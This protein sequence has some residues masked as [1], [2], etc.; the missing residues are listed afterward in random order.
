MKD[1]DKSAWLDFRRTIDD[2]TYVALAF[3]RVMDEDRSTYDALRGRKLDAK[4]SVRSVL[5]EKDESRA[6]E[7]ERCIE[8]LVDSSAY[9][10]FLTVIDDGRA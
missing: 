6:T 1:D 2:G 8:K 5:R 9:P 10:D 3:C 7:L 4:S